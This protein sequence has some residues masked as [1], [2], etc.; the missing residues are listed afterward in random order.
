[1]T[2]VADYPS[3]LS[4]SMCANNSADRINASF[5]RKSWPNSSVKRANMIW[6]VKSFRQVIASSAVM[7]S[8]TGSVHMTHLQMDASRSRAVSGLLIAQLILVAST[9]PFPSQFEFNLVRRLVIAQ[10][11]K[12]GVPNQTLGRPT[13]ELH[14]GDQ[15]RLH[16]PGTPGIL[17]R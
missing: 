9:L 17:G 15:L 7:M 6:R 2:S 3:P 13:A 12:G 5:N 11:S 10:A 14:L 16:E 4:R 8:A 1:M